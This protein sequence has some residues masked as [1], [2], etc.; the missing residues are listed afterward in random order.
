MKCDSVK[1]I[2]VEWLKNYAEES[3]MKGFVLGV[4]GGVDSALV[5]TLCCMTGLNTLVLS[6]PIHQNKD[7]LIRGN[8][9][10]SWLK[11]LYSNVCSE[12]IELTDAFEVIR[13][14]FPKDIADDNLA[15]AN[16][17][18]RLRMCALYAHANHSKYLVAGTGNKVEDY[19]VMFFTLGGDG[20]VD[21]SPIGDLSKSQIWELSRYLG[22]IDDI[23]SAK[24]TDGLWPDNRGDEDAI[25]ASYPELEWAMAECD[26]KGYKYGV[27]DVGVLTDFTGA[28][29]DRERQVLSIYL[30]RNYFGQHKINPIPICRIPPILL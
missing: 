7:Q 22:V 10:I 23:V 4:S 24:P 8:K 20:Q 13:G 1:R 25:G 3:G 21:L 16:L 14:I 6:L 27:L 17:R 30:N 28:Y 9:H 12:Y 2:I 19:G 15:M 29:S 18:S 5:S 26:L 11:S